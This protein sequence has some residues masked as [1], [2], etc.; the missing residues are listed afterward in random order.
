MFKR[1]NKIKIIS[2]FIIF[3]IFLIFANSLLVK[4]YLKK[5]LNKKIKEFLKNKVLVYSTISNQ[6]KDIKSKGKQISK[7]LKE[8]KKLNYQLKFLNNYKNNGLLVEENFINDFG[9]R[10]LNYFKKFK[11]EST[12]F[13]LYQIEEDFS[14]SFYLENYDQNII[15]NFAN[16]NTFYFD[17][18]DLDEKKL[19]IKFLPTNIKSFLDNTNEE[20]ITAKIRDSKIINNQ[21]YLSY[22][23]KIKQ[24]CYNTSIIYSEINFNFMEFKEFFTYSDCVSTKN[25]VSGTGGRIQKIS[26]K[27]I[28][29]TIGDQLNLHRAQDPNTMFGKTV[30]I[31]IFS[32]KF[33]IVTMGH[34]NPQ[35]LAYSKL[36]N[37]IFS[38]EHQSKGGDEINLLKIE[39]NKIFNYG[40]AI[41]SYGDHYDYV[42]SKDRKKYPLYKSH[43]DYGFEEPLIYFNPAI[44]PSEIV[45]E[46][47][48]ENNIDFLLST[49]KA[50]SLY[51][52]SYDVNNKKISLGNKIYIG[53]RIRDLFNSD[54]YILLALEGNSS[55]GILKK[56][57]G[58]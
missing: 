28:I 29:L 25:V 51:E 39:N 45:I 8:N 36:H 34:K 52:I 32:K 12:N 17:E 58:K 9:S 38:S 4:N 3:I 41:S 46:S 44:A 54:E 5:N 6:K 13:E 37:L 19:K 7:L 16:G 43:K 47:E 30:V 21:I 33:K 50:K 57:I 42:S 53:Q 14:G 26:D 18:K 1:N 10:K 11:I 2:V 55:I 23:K 31:D 22:T 27:N 49:L 20:N 40:W 15:V 48:N 56:K 35:G 24:S